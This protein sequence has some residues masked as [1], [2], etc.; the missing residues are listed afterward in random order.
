MLLILAGGK[1]LSRAGAVAE[2]AV[3]VHTLRDRS[4]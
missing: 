4:A 3:N 1:W 2:A